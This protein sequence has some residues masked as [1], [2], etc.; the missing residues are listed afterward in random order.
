MT[1]SGATHRQGNH[2]IGDSLM[3]AWSL[4]GNLLVTIAEVLILIM[5]P[6]I[7]P[8]ERASVASDAW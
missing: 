1:P 7:G 4:A 2:K 6:P 3:I 8:T 5:G